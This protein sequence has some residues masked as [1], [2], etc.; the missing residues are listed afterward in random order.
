M[1][2]I[3]QDE[4][5][6]LT[7]YVY[8]ISG[9][10]LDASKAYLLETRLKPMMQQYSCTSYME[11][12]AKAKADR[13]GNMEKEMI[14]AITTN[15]TFFFRDSSPFELFKHKILPDLV[16]SRARMYANMPVP[17]RIW[18]AACSTGQEVYSIAIILRETLGNLSNYQISILGTDISDDAVT[19][20]SYGKYN[21]FEAERGM[22]PQVLQKYFS[23]HGDGWKVKDEI[24]SMAV[25]RKFNLMKPFA[26]MGRFD[27]VFCR[28]VAIY[29]TATDKKAVFEKIAGVMETDGSLII[30]STESLN[31]VTSMFEPKRYLRSIFY[32]PVR[33]MDD[34]RGASPVVPRP[35]PVFPS[36]RSASAGP[37]GCPRIISAPPAFPS[38]RPVS[39]AA[40]TP[41]A[42]IP[43]PESPQR[44]AGRRALVEVP[45][46]GDMASSGHDTGEKAHGQVNAPLDS[47]V[48]ISR[49][50]PTK[51]TVQAHRAGDKTDLKRLLMQKKQAKA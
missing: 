25:F 28:N 17:I 41:A 34:R 16:D 42:A 48:S 22:P 24:R 50:P 19:K 23:A 20:A 27:V 30:G 7:R 35:V 13:S 39:S 46:A 45:F 26:G 44:E 21:K 11:L 5:K 2:A 1:T 12:Y 18:S 47:A 4:I 33:V 14:N 8:S 38:P 3:S 49:L 36:S 15:E 29:F 51:R 40:D 6:L 43:W 9:V 10:A 31:G 32:Q 37:Q